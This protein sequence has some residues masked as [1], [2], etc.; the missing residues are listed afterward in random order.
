MKKESKTRIMARDAF[1]VGCTLVIVIACIYKLTVTV[2]VEGSEWNKRAEEELSVV[3]KIQPERGAIVADDGSVLADNILTYRLSIDWNAENFGERHYRANYRALCDSLNKMFP[4]KGI[5]WW[6]KRMNIDRH[7]NLTDSAGNRKRAKVTMI[8]EKLDSVQ[9]ARIKQFPF[10]KLAYLP[11]KA[12]R[13]VTGLVRDQMVIRINPYGQLARRSIGFVKDS[14]IDHSSEWHGTSGLEKSLDSFLYGVPGEAHKTQIT[15][16]MVNWSTKK[17]VNGYD[18]YTTI[19]VQMQEILA[20]ELE[21]MCQK[22]N[23]A[24]GTAVLMEVKT[25]DIKAISNLGRLPGSTD[26]YYEDINRAV[27]GNELGSVLKVLSMLLALENNKVSFN[28]SVPTGASFVSGAVKLRDEHYVMASKTP[29]LIISTSSNIGIGKLLLRCF[30][31]NPQGY[32]DDLKNR[33][34][35]DSIGSGIAGEEKPHIVF[36]GKLSE[37]RVSLSRMSYG[38]SMH[39][40]PL[41]VLAVYNAIA[42]DG[43]YV[44][45]RLVKALGHDGVLDTVF[46]VS[47][48]RP[49]ICSPQNA[50][51]LREMMHGVVWNNGTGRSLKS[52]IVEI[53]GKTGTCYM[54]VGGN[55]D[56]SKKRTTFCGFFP[57]NN[58]KYS[59]SVVLEN[60][61]LGAAGG[62]GRVLLNVAEK[63]YARGLLD[64]TSDFTEGNHPERGVMF[65]SL[66]KDASTL[67]TQWGL[68]NLAVYATPKEEPAGTTPSVVGLG[69]RSAI[70]LLES[71]GFNVRVHGTGHVVKQEPAAGTPI[72]KDGE[73]VTLY[74]KI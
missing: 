63:L 2:F 27:R 55:Y 14:I 16:R 48:I 24:W 50:A 11:T 39:I 71:K 51:Y 53:A 70:A 4:E 26:Q 23:A 7:I 41:S 8:A 33:G 15:N 22:C 37:D 65:A 20:N 10:F 1:I 74:L 46:D 35:L 21:A 42:N 36:K 6:L 32:I 9:C 68:G 38:Y 52:D 25:G 30:E 60:G 13:V 61:N 62:C 40:P 5:D 3:R 31:K 66:D 49:Q 43:K 18:V 29:S 34:F 19:N 67:K 58:P 72:E 45:P 12:D 56:Y 59:G 69:V 73:C 44:R 57:Y 47:Y 17:A 64:N 28:E 54:L